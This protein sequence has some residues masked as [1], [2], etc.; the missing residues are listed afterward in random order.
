M[1]TVYVHFSNHFDLVWR[2]CW[3][4]SY[5]YEGGRYAS[6]RR[7]E[8]LCLL[9]NIDLAEQG[10]G[11]Y[12]VEQ[13]LSLRAFLESH[14]E[15]LPRIQKLHEQGL[16]EMCG[17]G[18]A[19]IDVNMCSGET[20]CRNMASGIRYCRDVLGLPPLLA[21]HGD[22][23]GSSAQFP[24]VIR[25]CGLPGIQGMSYSIPDNQYWRGLDGT[26]ALVWKGVPGRG[27]FFDHCYHEPCRVCRNQEPASCSACQGTGLDLPQ[28]FY[29]PF[30]PVPKDN[31]SD[32]LAVYNVCSEEMLPPAPFTANWRRWEVETPDVRYRWGTPRLTARL[33]EPLARAAD[34]PPVDKIASKIENNPVQSGC[35]VS[36]IRIKQMGRRL[37]AEFY[38]WEKAVMLSR[39]SGTKLD[40]GRWEKL[41]LELPLV[42]FHDAVTGTHQDEACREL[43]DRMGQAIAGIRAEARAALGMPVEK[44]AGVKPGDLIAVFAPQAAALSCRSLLPEVDWRLARPLVAVDEKGVRHPVVFPLHAYSPAL[45]SLPSRL[46]NA[47]GSDARTRPEL[48]TPYL[49]MASP[50]PLAW[51]R[52]R[53]EEA[54]PPKEQDSRLLRNAFLEVTLGDDGVAE[55]RD[56]KSGLTAKADQWTLGELLLEEDEGD[57]WGT[58]KTPAFRKGLRAFTHF[59]GAARF[60]G[61]QEA[62][63]SGRYEPNLPFGR[64]EDPNVFALEWLVTVRLLDEARR[65]DFSVEVFWKSADRRLRLAFPV[66]ASSDRGAYSIPAGWLMRNRYERKENHLWSPNGDWPALHFVAAEAAVCGS[67]WALVNQGTPSARIEDGAILMSVLRSPGFGHCLERYGQAY[68]MPTSGIRD[69]GWHRFEFHLLPY[70]GEAELPSLALQAIALNQNALCIVDPP[71]ASLN[72]LGL[73]LEGTD[74]ELQST[75]PCFNPE[76]KNALVLR[77]VNQAPEERTATLVLPAAGDYT[78]WECNLIE[79]AG[80][81]LRIIDHRVSL[82]LKPFEIRSL[83]LETGGRSS[84]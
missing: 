60:E 33:W 18:E 38:G 56:L 83:I 53:L 49:E 40:R 42:F 82:V 43:Q 10:E 73:R 1:K 80:E 52:M 84:A 81:R 9:R 74:V 21:N 23:F 61:Y 51:S 12:V 66:Q 47:V 32:G 39:G 63:Y 28:N 8:E 65:V 68:P 7:I 35:L 59:Q 46:I 45:P 6:Y 37:E 79:Q 48:T 5:V 24:Q 34:H 16:F 14:P 19:I 62:W 20:L 67:G 11:A 55:V 70:G 31:F 77:V 22:G 71:P 72:E 36:R 78:G 2:R 30:E 25:G 69:G 15:A 29:P 76:M 64:E 13:A 41:F 27:Y 26:S 57:P 58:R 44:P 75:K 4:R 50:K 54:L 3:D 17:A